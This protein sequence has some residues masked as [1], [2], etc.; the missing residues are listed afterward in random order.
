VVERPIDIQEGSSDRPTNPQT[1]EI[2]VGME[3]AKEGIAGVEAAWLASSRRLELT[4]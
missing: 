4:A 1:R 3:T 2:G